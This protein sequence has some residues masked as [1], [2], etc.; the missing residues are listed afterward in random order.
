MAEYS[1]I[2]K[3]IINMWNSSFT[4]TIFERQDAINVKFNFV[5]TFNSFNPTNRNSNKKLKI[6]EY[7][8]PSGN[9]II[10]SKD[11]IKIVGSVWL[12]PKVS[13]K[14]VI[15]IHG[16]NSS[17]F[18]VLYLTWHYRLLGYNILTFDFRNHGASDRDIVSWGYKEKWDL[19]AVINWLSSNYRISEIGLVG[20]S[21]GAFTAHY[22]LFS[23]QD[24]VK[25]NKIRWLVSDSAYMSV[26]NMIKD[27]VSDNAIKLFESYANSILED[28]FMIYKKEYDVD[29]AK[30]DFIKLIQKDQKYIPVMYIHNRFD[31][32]TSFL[33]SF[34]MHD[35]K[36]NIEH[37]DKNELIIYDEG[38]NHTKSII[39]FTND[40]ISR[41][42]KFVEKH[43]INNK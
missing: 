9:T 16:F 25:Q 8:K 18:D 24:F 36:N 5:K 20:T 4:K 6:K 42:L 3:A 32:V 28:I 13:D 40:Y 33:D 7:K 41:T 37:N 35:I 22:M 30:L 38:Y 11:G 43:Q 14:W 31:R 1:S 27:M 23:E 21:M 29:F 2:A 26:S 39:K 10:T 34:K 12:N 17:R 19:M 15:G